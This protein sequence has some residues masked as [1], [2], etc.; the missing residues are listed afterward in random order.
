LVYCIVGAEVPEGQTFRQ[1]DEREG[2]LHKRQG[3]MRRR[4]HQVNGHKFM[5]TYFR[6]PTFCSICRD[7]IWYVVFVANSGHVWSKFKTRLLRFQMWMLCELLCEVYL[8]SVGSK[9]HTHASI[10]LTQ[11]KER[12]RSTLIYS[13]FEW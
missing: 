3:A 10:K 9:E 12:A 8:A 13:N 5:A 1:K 2:P 7:F 4:V 6:Q 11:Q